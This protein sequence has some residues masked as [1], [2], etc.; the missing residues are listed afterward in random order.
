MLRTYYAIYD[1]KKKGLLEIKRYGDE[2]GV[3][4]FRTKKEAEGY[5]YN[6][7]ER[8]VKFNVTKIYEC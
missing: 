3:L 1:P 7:G 6:E 2:V 8:V 5:L 4:M